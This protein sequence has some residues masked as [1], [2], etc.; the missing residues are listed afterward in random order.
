MLPEVRELVIGVASARARMLREL[1]PL[2]SEQVRFQPAPETWSATQVLEHLVWAEHSGLNKMMVALEAWRAGEP[3]WVGENPNQGQSIET[4]VK[5][6]WQ[7][8]EKAPPVAEPRMGGPMPYWLAF[9]RSCQPVLEDVAEGVRPGELDE[10]IY[11]HFLSGP[12]TLRQRFEFLR[13]HMEHHLPQ[14]EK[15]RMDPAFPSES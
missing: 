12:L 10:V 6:T 14:V 7:P 1:E 11:P 5:R 15:L 2:S 13:F 8:K 9:F 4:I 3:V